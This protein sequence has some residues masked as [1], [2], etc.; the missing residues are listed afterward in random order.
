MAAEN[1]YLCAIAIPVYKK[2]LFPLEVKSFKQCLHVL[3]NRDVYLITYPELDCSI[4]ESI[5]E[6]EG[7]RLNK[8]FFSK[9]Y[10]NNID[11]YN[12]L[13]LDKLFYS[14]FKNYSYILIYQLDAYVFRDDIDNWCSKGYD[15]VGAP[16]FTNYSTAEEG[17][18]YAVGNGGF[19]LRRVAYFINLLTTRRWI[20]DFK[21]MPSNKGLFARIKFL[22][23]GYNNIDSIISQSFY[24]EDIFYCIFL[25]N[26]RFPLK[27]PAPEEA[28]AF[29]FEKSPSFLYKLTGNNLPMGCH[30]FE[31]NE[32]LSFWHD[33]IK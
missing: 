12:R 19:S 1:K 21:K 32:Y 17:S 11:G 5:A 24:N 31:K 29:S 13:V 30:A 33:I 18:L 20:F 6:S 28:A 25:R 15:Y 8:K 4:Y 9:S 23:R 7:I 27:V 3:G 16:W 2:E 14:E 26:S 10:F 22:L